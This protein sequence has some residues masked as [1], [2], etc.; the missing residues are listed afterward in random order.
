MKPQANPKRKGDFRSPF[1]RDRSRIIHSAAFRR[2]QGKTQVF[3]L[4]ASDFF[5]TRLTHS[6]EVAQIG[7]AI[8][9]KCKVA[10]PDLVE[11]ACLAHDIGHPPFGH[12]G[13]HKLKQLMADH[14]GF[15][16]N[17]QNL[18]IINKLETKFEFGGLNLTRASV[19]AL[20]KYRTAYSE[21]DKSLDI[22]RW[23]FR[24]DED[25]ELV[26][27]AKEGAP[28][29]PK[30]KSI[31]CRIMDWA[32]DIAYS[33]HDLEDGIKA[34]MISTEKIPR[35]ESRVR[36]ELTGR[37]LTWHEDIWKSIVKQIKD[38]LN[39]KG[40]Q[41]EQ[42]VKRKELIS[43]IIDEFISK[44]K[45][46]MHKDY[47]KYDTRYH[48]ELDVD[49][50]TI[51]KCEMMKCIVWEMIISDER[52][53]TLS[54]KGRNIVEALF[55]QFMDEDPWTDKMFPM[56]FRERLE[57]DE[58]RHRVVCDFVAGMTDTYALRMYSRI[59]ESDIHSVFDII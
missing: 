32:D 56:D 14:G 30:A 38:V 57:E 29:D 45:V 2:L 23:K 13:E 51:T 21:I 50:A 6:I 33:T 12:A 25:E 15:E 40:T 53:A 52:I 34:G 3:G 37:G 41:L 20:L 55:K 54:R 10:D 36:E 58:D 16:A 28:P 42:K 1:E 48:Y 17:A 11:L 9:L 7:K 49:K 44:T 35:V 22:D 5:R 4:G 43:K 27:W 47:S 19:D 31:E 39:V 26:S 59:M 46:K 24:Y 18:R 8:A